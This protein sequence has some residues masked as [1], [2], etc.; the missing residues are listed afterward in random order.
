MMKNFNT[1]IPEHNNEILNN[2]YLKIVKKTVTAG[3]KKLLRL[4]MAIKTII[5]PAKI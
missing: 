3:K 4:Y 2:L 1:K 5:N